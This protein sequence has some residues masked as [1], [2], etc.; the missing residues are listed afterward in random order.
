ME[1]TVAAYHTVY[2]PIAVNGV[3]ILVHK[4][5][6]EWLV[7]N[8]TLQSDA[9]GVAHR[10]SK[11][12]DDQT[13]ASF[14]AWG[15]F[16]K[17]IDLGDGWFRTQLQEDDAFAEVE[18]MV[19]GGVMPNADFEKGAE[20]NDDAAAEADGG[21]RGDAAQNSS[22]RV[23]RL[24][25]RIMETGTTNVDFKIANES[26]EG[27]H[28]FVCTSDTLA[29]KEANAGAAAA[30]DVALEANVAADADNLEEQDVK[31]RW[32]WAN[33]GFSGGRNPLRWS[34]LQSLQK[35]I[36]DLQSRLRG[37]SC[38]KPGC[39][40]PVRIEFRTKEAPRSRTAICLAPQEHVEVGV[41]ASVDAAIAE[42]S[43]LNGSEPPLKN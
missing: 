6:D 38:V 27:A 42:L 9:D 17:G 23:V 33:A 26:S 4:G 21:A 41:F 16:V 3:Q 20:A 18:A 13:P 29:R 39:D 19:E 32:M 37:A 15:S 1:E 35:A 28:G 8:S 11:Q 24:E 43:R 10:Q 31:V 14:A 5:G 2:L 36:A 22:L 34:N 7:D 40:R 30:I 12:L 25:E